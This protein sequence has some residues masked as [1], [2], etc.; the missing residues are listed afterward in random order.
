MV[1]SAEMGRPKIDNGYFTGQCKD[2]T[3]RYRGTG[4]DQCDLP[5]QKTEKERLWAMDHDCW[6]TARSDS[7]DKWAHWVKYEELNNYHKNYEYGFPSTNTEN[8]C[9]FM[10][11]VAFIT[12]RKIYRKFRDR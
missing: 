3:R 9:P 6:H 2:C 1:L 5:S 10:R 11:P 4:A 12:I 7:F 8:D